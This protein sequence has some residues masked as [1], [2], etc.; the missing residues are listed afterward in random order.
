MAAE[1]RERNQTLRKEIKQAETEMA[2][3]SAQRTDI[4]R[5]LFDPKSYEG[6][7]KDV[8]V[9][10]TDENA[11]RGRTQTGRRRSCAGSPPA[12]PRTA[13]AVESATRG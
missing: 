5:A 3:L 7:N 4:D 10:Q 8:P 11:H 2:R 12:K 9:S 13:L 6:S 1:A